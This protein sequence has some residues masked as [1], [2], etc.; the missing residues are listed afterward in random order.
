[1][2]ETVSAFVF[3]GCVIGVS[4][5]GHKDNTGFLTQ[6]LH[7]NSHTRRRTASNHDSAVFFDHTLGRRTSRVRLCLRIAG[8]KFDF[9]AVYPFALQC[10]GRKS[11]QHTAVAFTV[12]VFHGK[13][14]STQFVCAL[15]GVCARLWHVETKS[16]RSRIARIVYITGSISVF[17]K[18]RRR[19]AGHTKSGSRFQNT[20]S[21]EISLTH[22][23]EVL[24][25]LCCV[26]FKKYPQACFKRKNWALRDVGLTLQVY[27]PFVKEYNKR[28]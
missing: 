27:A 19:C 26:C 24:L 4:Q 21:R 11:I 17:D 8:Y 10:L 13:L 14:I 18:K 28:L 9:L 1:M 25:S 22:L 12:D 3:T 23:Y 15:V 6:T 20:P 7:S 5:S 16:D 2:T